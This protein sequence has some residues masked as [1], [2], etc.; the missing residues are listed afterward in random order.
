[1]SLQ[2][3]EKQIYKR[4]ED[5]AP[6]VDFEKKEIESSDVLDVEKEWPREEIRMTKSSR[7]K[8]SS[9]TKKKIF[10]WGIIFA[11]VALI[12]S[13]ALLYYVLQNRSFREKDIIFEIEYNEEVVSGME[14]TITIKYG[15]F[16]RV[17]LNNVSISFHR[18]DSMIM[19]EEEKT[20]AIKTWKIDKIAKGES[21]QMEIPVQIFGTEGS[22][23]LIA[24]EIQYMPANFNSF[25]RKKVDGKI[26][27]KSYP[28]AISVEAPDEIVSGESVEYVINCEN[29]S[30]TDFSDLTLK[31][32]P[33]FG[34]LL[35]E[36]MQFTDSEIKEAFIRNDN[37]ILID[38]FVEG[39]IMEFKLMGNLFGDVEEAQ[40]VD[41]KIGFTKNDNFYAYNEA[42]GTTIL[43]APEIQIM[44]SVVGDLENVDIGESVQF[45]IK[46]KNTSQNALSGVVVS[47]V[48]DGDA[49]DLSSLSVED[50]FISSNN[51]IEWNSSGVDNFG[52]L[53]SM[54][55]E[56]LEFSLKVKNTLPMNGGTSKNFVISS[57][58]SAKSESTEEPISG[59]KMSIKVN[60][61]L[62]VI[63]DGSYYN[64][65]GIKNFGPIPPKVGETTSYTI[66][67]QILNVSNDVRG[68]KIKAVLP[69]GIGW[70]NNSFTANG[71]LS[72]SNVTRTVMWDIGTVPANTGIKAPL[73]EAIFQISI[74]PALPDIGKTMLLLNKT[75]C[76]G[77]D[78]FTQEILS[79]TAD[80]KTTSLSED[81]NLSQSQYRVVNQ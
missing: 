70:G 45:V 59:N 76:S 51:V 16:S 23:H 68:T 31:I 74:K 17:D 48:L 49:I 5:D 64:N 13:S 9:G 52:Y 37:E 80:A 67:W 33:P 11:I 53:A 47:T 38:S 14:E 54:R 72:F 30:D 32:D 21:D 41:V 55:E 39:D 19:A 75:E 65:G 50:G 66:R 42:S 15:N 58:P 24:V 62:V 2:D 29:L 34:F 25:F 63:T 12:G 56:T 28:I 6:N 77:E 79:V 73:Y 4:G 18:P 27:I 44:Q 81:K 1:M 26:N 61:R 10:I 69:P 60:S 36:V 57:T 43:M 3:L 40:N 35:D 8:I 22:A 78:I 7:R 71:N 46:V 20:I